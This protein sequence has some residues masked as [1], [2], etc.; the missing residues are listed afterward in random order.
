MGQTGAAVRRRRCPWRRITWWLG[1]GL[2]A[3][4]VPASAQ[5]DTVF[6]AR[7]TLRGWEETMRMAIFDRGGSFFG[8]TSEKG[9]LQRFNPVMDYEYW[10]DQISM[11]FSLSEEYH[12][13]QRKNGARY[14]AGSINHV[15]L[16]Q[17]AD[18][19]ATVALGETWGV[20]VW[21][22]HDQ[23]LH[24][25]RGLLWLGF[26]HTLFAGRDKIFLKA[27]LKTDKPETD[28]ELGY[29]WSPGTGE[30][31]IAAAALDLFNNF[32]YGTLGIPAT[33]RDTIFDYTSHP[34]TLRTA[35]D[36]RV[37]RLFRT[38][39]YGLY[40]TPARVVAESQVNEGGGFV[41]D[42]EFAYAGGLV[43]WEP[44]SRSALGGFGTW[45]RARLDR[46]ALP[47]GRPEDDFD[48]EEKTW[49]L[50]LYGIHR[51]SPRYHLEARVARVWRTE[52]RVRPDTTVAPNIDYED[53]SWA[54]RGSF[55]FQARSGFRFE[56][57]LDFQ[58]QDV[59]KFAVLPGR[60]A[61]LD[62]TRARLDFGWKFDRRA[63]LI[64]GLSLDLD[65]NLP[66]ERGFDG[67]HG[68]F[69][70]YF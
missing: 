14:W 25:K 21:F 49:S 57:G 66:D 18:F 24:Q 68:R 7:A 31:T 23:T 11:S 16:A 61:G 58:T 53:R 1:L 45:V 65:S 9:I 55:V 10:L 41:Q 63:L 2:A 27:T 59:V 30:I 35:V 3:S 51:F 22:R 12:W 29:T 20:N 70:L 54:G 32:I 62:N 26:D 37:G 39:V 34:Y 60:F 33:T 36:Y 44:S 47:A 4:A 5:T 8:R 56:L 42:E 6:A 28:I 43:E 46:S 64:L 13:Y 38:E 48:L 17:H 19:K 40:M 50:G 52:T 15:Q 69:A 67:A